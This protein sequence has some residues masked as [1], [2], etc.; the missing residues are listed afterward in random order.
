[1]GTDQGQAPGSLPV[2]AVA[3]GPVH[4]ELRGGGRLLWVELRAGKG[5]VLSMAVL[6]ALVEALDGHRANPHIRAA[7]IRGAGGHFSFGASVEEHRKDQAAQMLQVFHASLRS[8]AS[9]PAPV[10]ALVEGKCLGG[11]F[12]LALVCDV[13]LALPNAGFACPEIKLGVLPPVL[14][15]LG[16]AKL[17]AAWTQKLVLT[18]AELPL[19]AAEATGFATLLSAESA[20]ERDAQTAATA[21]LE[22]NL[23]GQSAHSLRVAT[24]ALRDAT[25][26]KRALGGALDAAEASYIVELIP[27][28]DGNEGIEAFLSRR[29]P[30]WV[31]A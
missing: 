24:A 19:A 21:W 26:V 13:V 29:P 10:V 14:V 4:A 17:G 3:T 31:D 30:Q 23:L 20:G 16:G 6:Q 7:V 8:V 22:K 25:G 18:G 15:A 2:G 27:S 5:N 1:M 28:H 12:E 9:F 11:A